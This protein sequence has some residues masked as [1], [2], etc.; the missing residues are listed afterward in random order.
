[1]VVVLFEE[2][3][4]VALLVDDVGAEVTVLPVPF[5]I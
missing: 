2:V 3:V 1:V 5:D 4:E